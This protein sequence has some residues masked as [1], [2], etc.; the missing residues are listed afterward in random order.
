MSYIIQLGTKNHLKYIQNS[1]S[2][3]H[4]IVKFQFIGRTGLFRYLDMVP[5]VNIHLKIAKDF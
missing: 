1:K 2:L 3:P 4:L 5:A